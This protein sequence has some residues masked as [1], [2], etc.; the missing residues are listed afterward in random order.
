MLDEFKEFIARGN[1]IDLA[2]GVIIGGAFGK[3]VTSLTEDV[4]MPPVGMALGKIDFSSLFLSLNGQS[5][6]SLEV[7]RA[8]GAPVLAWGLFL[9]N[10]VNF[11]IVAFCIFLLVKAINRFHRKK[12]AAPEAPAPAVRECPECLSSVPLKARRCP[13]CTSALE[14]AA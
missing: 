9:N 4:L 3:I 11:L 13:H 2:V 5:Y 7:A 6:P 1:V 14:P 12:E 8:A 10:V